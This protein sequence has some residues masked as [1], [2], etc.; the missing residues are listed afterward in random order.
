[1]SLSPPA[2]QNHGRMGMRID[3]AWHNQ[4]RLQIDF[5]IKAAAAEGGLG[6]YFYYS[7]PFNNKITRLINVI[8]VVKAD[9]LICAYQDGRHYE[10]SPFSG[11]IG[12]LER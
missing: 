11:R 12:H 4:V 3:Q 9:N 8:F 10:S 6:A 7:A 2:K 5:V 1:M